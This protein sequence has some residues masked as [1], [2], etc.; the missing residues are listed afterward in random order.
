LT[1]KITVGELTEYWSQE[2]IDRESFNSREQLLYDNVLK[3]SSDHSTKYFNSGRDTEEYLRKQSLLHD[4]LVAVVDREVDPE[5]AYDEAVDIITSYAPDM[6]INQQLGELR[7]KFGGKTRF[8]VLDDLEEDIAVFGENYPG[9]VPNESEKWLESNGVRGFADLVEMDNGF[10]VREFKTG[11]KRERDQFQAAT[12]GLLA[13]IQAGEQ[14]DAEVVY[15]PEHET[16]DVD[17]DMMYDVVDTWQSMRNDIQEI[18]SSV[19][20]DLQRHFG[21]VDTSNL[22]DTVRLLKEDNDE[23]DVTEALETLTEHEVR[24]NQ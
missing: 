11:K 2:Q 16:V 3:N 18:R 7:E 9:A 10:K 6:N 23:D 24:M 22:E 14:V 1:D 4:T 19:Q 13:S 17:S 20:N 12:Y 8:E 15:A 5:E 21:F